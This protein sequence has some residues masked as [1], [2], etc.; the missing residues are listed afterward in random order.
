MNVINNNIFK[1]DKTTRRTVLHSRDSK[2]M[3]I[4]IQKRKFVND[5]Q[6]I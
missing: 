3:S 5:E 1:D 2:Q 6:E 4:N